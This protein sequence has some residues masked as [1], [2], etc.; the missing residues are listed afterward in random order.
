MTFLLNFFSA[1]LTALFLENI[2]FARALGTSWLLYMLKHPK[3]LVR[4]S[5]LL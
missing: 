4:Y 1:A 2:V 5:V 3:E